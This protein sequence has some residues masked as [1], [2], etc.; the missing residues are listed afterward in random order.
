MHK[1]RVCLRTMTRIRIVNE[2]LGVVDFGEV[3]AEEYIQM[4]LKYSLRRVF[5]TL[6]NGRTDV[7]LVRACLRVDTKLRQISTRE[8]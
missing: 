1:F 3:C 4:P 7:K 2:A 6:S 5:D 8:A